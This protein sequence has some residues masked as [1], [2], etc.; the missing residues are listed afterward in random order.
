MTCNF[1]CIALTD[2]NYFSCL[3]TIIFPVIHYEQYQCFWHC[4]FCISS[5]K[6]FF[7]SLRS[8]PPSPERG[9]GGGEGNK[10]VPFGGPSFEK[11][12]YFFTNLIFDEELLNPL[13]LSWN[14]LLFPFDNLEHLTQAQ[15]NGVQ[16]GQ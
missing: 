2:V 1:R 15:H 8:R 13:S 3:T 4:S 6:Y 9:V 11:D 7:Y 12:H 5:N 16:D 14:S 10:K